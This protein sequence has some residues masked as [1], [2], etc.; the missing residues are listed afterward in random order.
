MAAGT[1]AGAS[2]AF[3][4]LS[5]SRGARFHGHSDGDAAAVAEAMDPRPVAGVVVGAEF[6]PLGGRN[7][8]LTSTLVVQPIG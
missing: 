1:A 2:G 3:A 5:A 8:R 7:R 4:V 6:T